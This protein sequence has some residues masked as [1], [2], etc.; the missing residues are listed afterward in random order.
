MARTTKAQLEL[1]LASIEAEN[2]RLL[3][4][5]AQLQ[6]TQTKSQP[7]VP[8]GKAGTVTFTLDNPA[9]A[10][11]P[12]FPKHSKITCPAHGPSQS[13]KLGLCIACAM[14][15]VRPAVA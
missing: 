5:L 14:A 2:V 9:F 12:E 15:R 4:E 1:R 11:L 3:Q 10:G 8:A 7:M 13:N 6:Q